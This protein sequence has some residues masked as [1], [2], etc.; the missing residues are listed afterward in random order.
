MA[1]VDEAAVEGVEAT[2]VGGD[3]FVEDADFGVEEEREDLVEAGVGGLGD[4]LFG[5]EL[6]EF[7][8]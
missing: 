3:V 4:G 6:V 2:T 5:E 8:G 1:G 7:D